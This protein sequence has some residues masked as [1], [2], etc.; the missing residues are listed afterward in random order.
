MADL[1]QAAV[2]EVAITG[3]FWCSDAYHLKFIPGD[4]A[5]ILKT[6]QHDTIATERRTNSL[7]GEW[8]DWSFSVDDTRDSRFT[9]NVCIRNHTNEWTEYVNTA[10]WAQYIR[11]A[12]NSIHYNVLVELEESALN[13]W[14]LGLW[15]IHTLLYANRWPK[16]V[17]VIT[18][19]WVVSY[20][21]HQFM[22]SIESN[23]IWR[24]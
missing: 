14:N 16:T 13:S 5:F 19:L 17:G 15:F 18:L 1:K 24:I 22:D 23:S 6:F 2:N 12:R 7:N 8:I 9:D 3:N 20:C 4:N 10:K 21:Y 11:M